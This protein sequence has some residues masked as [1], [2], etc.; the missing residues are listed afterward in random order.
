MHNIN[1]ESLYSFLFFFVEKNH[2]PIEFRLLLSPD[3]DCESTACDPFIIELTIL[4]G[5]DKR[6]SRSTSDRNGLFGVNYTNENIARK[7]KK[8][9]MNELSLR[10]WTY[11]E[12]TS[13]VNS[14]TGVVAEAGVDEA[15][16]VGSVSIGGVDEI[17]VKADV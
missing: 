14:T 2:A 4:V 16:D 15:I 5:R 12:F 11:F 9:N 6:F 17:G 1:R 13:S 10:N 8:I 7:K 3:R